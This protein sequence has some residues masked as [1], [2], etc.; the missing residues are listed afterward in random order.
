MLLRLSR[1][2]GLLFVLLLL[3]LLLFVLLFVEKDRVRTR[4]NLDFHEEEK[5]RLAI[6][7]GFI[8]TA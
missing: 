3:L 5:P 1:K 4:G 2:N 6:V 8:I 7:D